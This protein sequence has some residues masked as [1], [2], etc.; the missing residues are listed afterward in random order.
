[1]RHVAG[2]ACITLAS[3]AS[4]IAAGSITAAQFLKRFIK[5]GTRWAHIDIAGVAWV[6]GEKAPTD[7]SWASGYGPRL[8][9]RWIA[10]NY[11]A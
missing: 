10:D 6:E 3:T 1:M 2:V 9:S 4:S 8:L 5:D 7:P 11:E